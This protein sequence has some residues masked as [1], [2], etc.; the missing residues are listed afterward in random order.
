MVERRLG[1]HSRSLAAGRSG[2][3]GP[4]GAGRRYDP[5]VTQPPAARPDLALLLDDELRYDATTS[6]HLSNHLPMAL[7]ALHALGADD[8]RLGAFARSY[9]RRLMPIDDDGEVTTFDEWLAARGRRG[10]YGAVRRYFDAA[11]DRAGVDGTL[12]RHLPE[13]A[14][15]VGGGAFHGV[16][17]LAYALEAQSAPRIAAGLA[18]FTEVY[19]PLGHRGHGSPWTRDPIVALRQLCD[20]D[21]LARISTGANIGQRMRLVG[22]HP[23]FA[24]VIDSLA[25]DEG[26]PAALTAAA[27]ALY[28]ATDDFTALHGV[29]GSHA[30]S[31]IAPY[32]EDR[33]TLVAH[34]FQALAAAYMTIG[35]PRIRPPEGPLLMLI[36][37]PPDWDAIASSACTSPDEHV[38]KLVY[39]AREL[40]RRREDPLLAAVAARQAGLGPAGASS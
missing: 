29:T 37:D 17:R 5:D 24:G 38:I 26:T 9:A 36:E 1:L 7:V 34:W 21:A 25:V 31:I 19:L 12:R 16:I 8:E 22:S 23:T 32:V 40:D 33:D 6:T 18:Y 20:I 39:T 2:V 4:I 13:L 3:E 15:G 11:I 35:A 30:I 28:A 10:S 27:V 14:A